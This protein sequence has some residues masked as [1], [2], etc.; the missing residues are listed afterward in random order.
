MG[1]TEKLRPKYHRAWAAGRPS[2]RLTQ[3][4]T[5][6][7]ASLNKGRETRLTPNLAGFARRAAQCCGNAHP[8]PTDDTMLFELPLADLPMLTALLIGI[9]VP[10]YL[11]VQ[12]RIYPKNRFALFGPML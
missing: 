10:L 4:R 11:F 7:H 8:P 6:A 5:A 2:I 1:K 9:A 3:G 12:H